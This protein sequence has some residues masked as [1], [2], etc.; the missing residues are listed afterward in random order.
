MGLYEDAMKASVARKN[1]T[2]KR[3]HQNIAAVLDWIDTAEQLAS[4]VGSEISRPNATNRVGPPSGISTRALMEG[5][6][7]GR[8][9]GTPGPMMSYNVLGMPLT[10]AKGTKKVFKPFLQA[11]AATGY[12]ISSVGGY[13]N[14]NIAGT[15]TPSEHKYG[16]AIDINPGQNPVTYGSHITTNLPPNIAALARKYGLVWGGTWHGSKKDP[17]H[18]SITGY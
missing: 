13:A 10:T 5:H 17:M 11:L 3:T 18:F 1:A 15:N 6:G 16:K 7:T 14:R 8:S 4:P 12:K 9:T 2:V